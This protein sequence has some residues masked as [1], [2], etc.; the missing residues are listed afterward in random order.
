MYEESK[1]IELQTKEIE[2][3]YAALIVRLNERESIL[4]LIRSGDAILDAVDSYAEKYPGCSIRVL[5]DATSARYFRN[6]DYMW[7]RW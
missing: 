5:E 1:D 2:R 3:V 4:H 6:L 7:H